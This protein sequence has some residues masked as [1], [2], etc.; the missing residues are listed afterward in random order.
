MNGVNNSCQTTVALFGVSSDWQSSVNG[1]PI[2]L[3][4]CMN[5]WIWITYQSRLTLTML[6]CQKRIY[7]MFC[8]KYYMNYFNN[9]LNFN[10]IPKESYNNLFC[11]EELFCRAPNILAFYGQKTLYEGVFL[12]F[13]LVFLMIFKRIIESF[14]SREWCSVWFPELYAFNSDLLWAGLF[15]IFYFKHF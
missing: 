2:S 11:S 13:L 15:G 10:I 12:W 4:C 8:F 1:L 9:K 5:Y 7:G 6:S 14:Q 3:Q